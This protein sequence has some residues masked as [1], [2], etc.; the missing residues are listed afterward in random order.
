MVN[1]WLGTGQS[2]IKSL[3][4]VNRWS[5]KCHTMSLLR[6]Q[7]G[8]GV[9]HTLLAP[10]AAPALAPAVGVGVLGLRGRWLMQAASDW[11]INVWVTGW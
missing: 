8:G 6:G 9:E 1:R 5:I 3:V 10:A 2:L 7:L 4:M 11:A